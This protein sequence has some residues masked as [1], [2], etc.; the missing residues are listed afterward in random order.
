MMGGEITVK[1]EPGKGSCFSFQIHAGF[2]DIPARAVSSNF[3]RASYLAPGQPNYRILVAED[4]SVNRLL[5]VKILR[6]LGF[7]VQEA[8]NGQQAITLWQTWHPHLIFMDMQMPI[9]DGYEATRKIKHY[10][11]ENSELT[12][13][14]SPLP[15]LPI[16]IA[17]TASAFAEQRQECFHAGCD[18]FVGKPFRRQE[19]IAILAKYLGVKYDNEETA[20]IAK[21][22]R[23]K[24][25]IESQPHS[26]LDTNA[27]TI[28]PSEW[29]AQL[30]NAAAQGD[31]RASLKLI[32]QIPPQYPSLIDTLTKLVETYQF[33]QLIEMI[34]EPMESPNRGKKL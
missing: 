31:D 21:S 24:N 13:Q 18:A 20:T 10:A 2:S 7:E 14:N 30:H 26:A 32:S 25:L 3:D 12:S 23:A 9:V 1:S 34:A 22:A 5:L 17:I 4:T 29:I 33:H 8:Q 11:Q 27:W 6:D 16:I 15:N 19:I 28:M